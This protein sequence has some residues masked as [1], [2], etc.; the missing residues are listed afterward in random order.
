MSTDV[1][2]RPI[3]V[4]HLKLG[5]QCGG[6]DGFS[7][8]TANPALGV[9]SDILV[10]HG[11]TSI[12]SETPEI[13]GAEDVLLRRA[14]TPAVA[15]DLVALL[16]WWEDYL[17]KNGESMDSNPSPGNKAG[18]LTTILEKSLG[19]TAKGGLSELRAVYRYAEPVTAQGFVYMDTPGYDPVSVTGQVAGGANLICFTTGR[20]SC[21]GCKP[22][23][24]LKLAT[25]TPMYNRMQ[26]DMD[27]NCGTIAEGQQ[28]IAEVGAAIYRLLLATASGQKTKSELLGYGEEEFAPWQLGATL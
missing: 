22:A 7:A 5:L 2:R 15:H 16:E 26:D 21:F 19:A 9:A 1:K 12:L 20:G 8:L 14:A 27:L 28:S 4:S 11:G 23:P 13:Y 17:A 25:N 3:S 24:S 18:G 6:S 10:Q